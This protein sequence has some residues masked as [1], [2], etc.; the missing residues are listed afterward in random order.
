MDN[1]LLGD[2]K[3]NVGKSMADPGPLVQ[4]EGRCYEANDDGDLKLFVQGN[5]ASGAAYSYGATGKIDGKD[6]R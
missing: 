1:T 6:T 5:A 3:L 4:G 2:W